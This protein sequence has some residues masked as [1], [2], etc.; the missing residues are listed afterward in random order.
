MAEHDKFSKR[1]CVTMTVKDHEHLT[2]LAYET[3]R[4]RS[5]YMR[6]LLHQDFMERVFYYFINLSVGF[7]GSF[8]GVGGGGGGGR[9]P[10]PRL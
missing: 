3:L 2:R 10:P 6:W 7:V 9:P 1:V 4:T 5:G 8:M